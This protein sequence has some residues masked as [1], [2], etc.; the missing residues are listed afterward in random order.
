MDEDEAAFFARPKKVVARN[1]KALK[2]VQ[3][4][5]ES[6]L[7]THITQESGSDSDSRSTTSAAEQE[8]L[9]AAL[10]EFRSEAKESSANPSRSIVINLSS[11]SDSDSANTPRARNRASRSSKHGE[12]TPHRKRK[13]SDSLTPPPKLTEQLRYANTQLVQ[14]VFRPMTRPLDIFLPPDI[15]PDEAELLFEQ[16]MRQRSFDYSDK[17]NNRADSLENLRQEPGSTRARTS[18]PVQPELIPD[19]LLEAVV[20]GIYI[21]LPSSPALIPDI[22]LWEKPR[23]FRIRLSTRLSVAKVAFCKEAGLC[24]IHNGQKVV[25]HDNERKQAEIVLVYRNIRVFDNVTAWGLGIREGEQPC[26]EA[27]TKEGWKYLELN[28]SVRSSLAANAGTRTSDAGDAD[29]TME[30]NYH[31]GDHE[32][33]KQRFI[34]LTIRAEDGKELKVRTRAETSISRLIEGFK[35]R[36][37][38][39]QDTRLGLFFE[40]DELTG[41]LGDSE[42]ESDDVI[43]I[44]RLR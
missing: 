41:V 27:H 30:Q 21:D 2:N 9:E 38:I 14:D 35:G 33:A 42:V 19:T 18:E 6:E 44:K 7:A 12:T 28:P 26:F 17:A 1:T 15:I 10:R 20:Q 32:E 22:Q 29:L 36:H 24:V 25:D 13:R 3:Q 34:K 40:G 5:K 43:D 11:E 37:M 31:T 4:R 16:Q 23:L 39:P 8:A